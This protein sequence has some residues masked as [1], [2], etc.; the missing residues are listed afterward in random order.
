M[1]TKQHLITKIPILGG[2]CHIYRNSRSGEIWQFQQ[3]LKDERRY[4]RVSL[5]AIDRQVAT[6]LAEKKFADTLGR[7]HSGEKI[8]SITAKELVAQYLKHLEQRVALGSIRVTFPQIVKSHLKHYLAFVEEDT[9]IQTIPSEKFREYAHHRRSQSPQPGFLT[10]KDSQNAIGTMYRWAIEEQLITRKSLPKWEE[11]RIPATEGKRQG[12]EIDDYNKIVTVSKVWDKKG[13]NDRDKYERKHLHNFIVIQSWYGMRTGEVLGLIW[14]DVKFRNDGNAEVRIREVTTKR[15]KARMCMGRGDIFHRIQSY[16][17]YT[18]PTNHVFSSFIAGTEWKDGLFYAR[19]RE[20]V[21]V[22]KQK[23]P[24]FDT[25][26]SLYDLR[27]F[28]ISSHLRAGDSPWLIAKYCG[29][30][31]EMIGKH[32][33]NVTD[34]QVSKKILSKQMKF[35]GDEV[36][37]VK[38][39]ERMEGEDE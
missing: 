18:S 8:F 15:G 11:F 23:Y 10:I 30:S 21:G 7:I 29:T 19:W 33:D 37:G 38:S 9:K 36:I 12:M 3:W 24:T 16:S 35:V 4:V 31:A 20:L 5:K 6:E 14:S 25:S 1:K 28:Y 32:Y 39:N 17:K 2:K 22:V 13:T 27:H 34:L 26:K